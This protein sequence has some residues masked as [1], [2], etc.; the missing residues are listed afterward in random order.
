MLSGA[1]GGRPR[2]TTRWA[3]RSRRSYAPGADG[4]TAIVEVAA[5]RASALVDPNERDPERARA[6]ERAS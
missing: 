6:Q 1:S 2:R 3:A 5:A 4:T